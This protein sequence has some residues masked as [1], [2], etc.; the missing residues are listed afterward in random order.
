MIL[1]TS[2]KENLKKLNPNNVIGYVELNEDDEPY[3]EI[4]SYSV[5]ESNYGI[6]VDAIHA[7]F[8]LMEQLPIEIVLE[9]DT[10]LEWYYK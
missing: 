8:Q 5:P 2:S 1:I 10:I 9:N 7:Y 3:S 4:V 6:L